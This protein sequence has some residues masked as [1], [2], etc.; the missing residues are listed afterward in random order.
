MFSPT[1]FT[2]AVDGAL[3]QL[4]I[5]QESLARASCP[6]ITNFSFNL[7]HLTSIM[8]D[9]MLAAIPTGYSNQKKGNDYIYIISI[10]SEKKSL[11]PQLIAGLA[12]AR[13]AAA[14]DYSRVNAHHSDSGTLYV[15]RSKTLRA[16]LKQHLGNG[17]HGVYS[18]HLERWATHHDATLTVSFMCFINQENLLVQSLEDGLW[19]SLKPAFGRKGE[20]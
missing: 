5:A 2:V 9:E 7:I 10:D 11:M 4:Q 12:K 18:L 17:G 13:S 19:N 14:K 8:I 15:G 3:S 20:R 6:E 16:R 1:D